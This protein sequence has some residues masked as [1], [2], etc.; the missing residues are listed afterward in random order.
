VFVFRFIFSL[1]QS[2]ITI[3]C[4]WRVSAIGAHPIFQCFL[5]G[6]HI[7]GLKDDENIEEKQNQRERMFDLSVTKEKRFNILFMSYFSSF[8]AFNRFS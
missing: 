6:L 7:C 3:N 2:A 8:I 5:D 4:P 1:K